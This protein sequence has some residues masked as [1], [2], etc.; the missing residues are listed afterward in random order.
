MD[1]G[2]KAEGDTCL[3]NSEIMLKRVLDMMLYAVEPIAG[4]ARGGRM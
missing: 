1:E 4:G 2:V 3:S